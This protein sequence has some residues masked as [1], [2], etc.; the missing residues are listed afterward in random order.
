MNTCRTLN[1]IFKI[2]NFKKKSFKLYS[3]GLP[4]SLTAFEEE[5]KNPTTFFNSKWVKWLSPMKRENV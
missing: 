3:I 4:P 2:D 5:A 1:L